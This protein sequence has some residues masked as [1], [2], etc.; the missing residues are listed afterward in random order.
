M[1]IVLLLISLLNT[2]YLFTA[3]RT[4]HL[5]LRENL[6]DSP[7]A[8]MVRMDMTDAVRDM[9]TGPTPSLAWRIV[10]GLG[11]HVASAW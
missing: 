7:R 4:Y 2:L 1:T 10:R 11:A 6:V 5:H 8:R 9:D 3:T